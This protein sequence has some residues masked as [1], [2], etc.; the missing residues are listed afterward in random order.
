VKSNILVVAAHPDDE[1]IGMGGSIKKFVDNGN[2]LYLCM[3]T[4]PRPGQKNQTC[5]DEE[6][7][8]AA[9]YLGIKKIFNLGFPRMEL[10]SITQ[11]KINNEIFKIMKI[12]KP[13]T[14]F[15]HYWRDIN[16]DHEIVSRATIV[17]ARPHHMSNI[18]RIFTYEIVASTEWGVPSHQRDF[19]PTMYIDISKHINYKLNAMKI[20]KSQ[21]EKFPHPRSLKTIDMLA[22]KRGSEI[23]VEAAEGFVPLRIVE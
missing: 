21:L 5:R 2:I 6:L 1:T 4:K 7:E 14:V 23:C 10:D 22:R 15:T 16:I 13:D 20:Q 17:A 9:E 18:K 11:R 12:V 8:K 19:A 3:V